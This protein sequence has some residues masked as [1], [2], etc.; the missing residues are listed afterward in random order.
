MPHDHL[1]D[2]EDLVGKVPSDPA[3]RVK[4]LENLPVETGLVDPAAVDA[5]EYPEHLYSM[6]FTARERWGEAAGKNDNLKA[7]GITPHGH[8]VSL[9]IR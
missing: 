6:M 4:A 5:C 9:G 7:Y 8:P 1:H 2:H 3:L